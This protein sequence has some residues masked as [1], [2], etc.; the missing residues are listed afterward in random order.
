MLTR[1][2]HDDLTITPAEHPGFEPRRCA[3]LNWEGKPIG[4]LGQVKPEQLDVDLETECWGAEIEL[5]ELTAPRT[6]RY[7]P[8]SRE[9]FVKRDLDLVVD[10]EQ[11][12]QEL[13]ST[14]KDCAQWLDRTEIFDLYRGQ[15]LPDDKKSVSFRLYFRAEDRTLSDDEVNETQQEILDAL[16]NQH[17][18]V[19]RDE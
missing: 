6:T 9:P 18:A 5:S 13:T 1:A 7:R 11:Y 16:R 12:A 10:R 3:Q 19:L 14:I 4:R 15:P 8:F 17:G 2:G